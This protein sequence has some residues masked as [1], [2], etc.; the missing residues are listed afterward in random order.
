MINANVHPDKKAQ[1]TQGLDAT[2][3]RVWRPQGKKSKLIRKPHLS[4]KYHVNCQTGCEVIAIFVYPTRPSAAMLD[5]WNSKV[6]PLDRPTLIT[7]P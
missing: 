3:V 7:P 5:F 4:T 2:A 6:T 1:L